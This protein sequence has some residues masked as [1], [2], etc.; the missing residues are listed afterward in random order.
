MS[1][2][3]S[4]PLTLT[5]HLLANVDE[6]RNGSGFTILLASIQLACKTISHAVRKAGII[7]VLGLDGSTNSTGDDVKK[8]DLLSND[9]FINALRFSRELC[10]LVSEEE[11]KPLVIED[12]LQGQY[13]VAT[14][15]LDG[16]SNIDCNI[17]TGTIFGIYRRVP[18]QIPGVGDVLRPGKELIAAGYCMYGSSTQLVLTVGDGVNGFTLDPS[19]GEFILTHPNIRIPE[20][21]KTIYSV[22]E[23]NS[24][25]W[26]SA[27]TAFVNHCKS[28]HAKP[29]SA[30]YVGSMVSDV[31]RTL[32]YGGVFMYPGDSKSPNGKLRLLYEGNPMAFLCEQAGGVA[33]DGRE[34]I[35]DKVPTDIHCRT[36]I[37]LGC[38]RDMDTVSEFFRKMDADGDEPSHKKAKH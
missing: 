9:V 21:P 18:G 16:S 22:N 1:D 17:S 25:Y 26:D 34:R 20:K 38:K 6:K 27:T 36:P 19:I 11:E 15:P 28:G 23:G 10:V 37:F 35:L 29:Y 30:R 4:D 13:C 8:L 33:T 5:R 7:G 32:Q 14:D 24:K 2:I 3:S 12:A 31:H